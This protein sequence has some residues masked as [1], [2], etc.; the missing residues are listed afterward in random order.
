MNL[1]ELSIAYSPE[2]E[3]LDDV[4]RTAVTNLM[5]QNMRDL[6][7]IF[8]EKLPENIT[9]IIES[10]PDLDLNATEISDFVKSRIR[11]VPYKNSSLI[12]G[13]Y[14]DEANTRKVI[15]AVEFDDKLYGQ[16]FIGFLTLNFL[17]YLF[18]VLLIM[19]IYLFQ[20]HIN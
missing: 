2:S 15:A 1:S 19:V 8:I 17:F 16:Y 13:I 14:V 3:V 20:E 5:V 9:N 6:I 12:R 11:I 7:P 18:S 10:L 4:M